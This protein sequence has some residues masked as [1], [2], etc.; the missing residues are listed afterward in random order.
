MLATVKNYIKSKI[1]PPVTEK[2]VVEAYD[3]WASDYDMQPGNLMLHLDGILFKGLLEGLELNGKLV[4]DIG[5]G[6]GRQWPAIFN[7]KPAA[8]TG[9]DVSAGMLKKLKDKYPDAYIRKITNNLF[10]D[11]ADASFDIIVSTLTV[12]HIEDIDEA[13]HA[14]SRL[15]KAGGEI[16]I[17]DFHPHT[18]ASGGKRTFKHGNRLMAVRNYIHPIFTIKEALISNGFKLI[19]QQ[20]IKIDETM[21]LFYAD[22]NALHVYEKYLG[23]PVIYGIHLKRD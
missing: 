17:T 19:T 16:I 1:T 7:K 6:T 4:A 3:L 15:L 23:F 22:A 11:V 9:F 20:E 21:K 10:S 8:L 14:W 2:S 13:M 5:C 12:A 18:L